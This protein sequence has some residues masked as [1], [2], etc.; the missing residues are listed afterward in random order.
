MAENEITH[1]QLEEYCKKRDLVIV[2]HDYFLAIQALRQPNGPKQAFIEQARAYE[3][4]I[5]RQSHEIEMLNATVIELT[6][7]ATRA[8]VKYDNIKSLLN[9]YVATG[10]MP[11]YF[12]IHNQL[13]ETKVKLKDARKEAA[14]ANKRYKQLKKEFARYRNEHTDSDYNPTIQKLKRDIDLYK[15]QMASLELNFEDY[16]KEHPDCNGHIQ[17][18]DCVQAFRG[19]A[20]DGS[21]ELYCRASGGEY[22]S[23]V[24]VCPGFRKKEHPEQSIVPRCEDCYWSFFYGEQLCCSAHDEQECSAVGGPCKGFKP[25]EEK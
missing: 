16:K 14:A 15:S 13:C 2:T 3:T 20:S 25:K 24:K 10:L 6:K 22:V 5:S 19:I 8:R 11:G 9:R 12:D 4:K 17:C 1:E 18:E 7:C 23:N 21:D